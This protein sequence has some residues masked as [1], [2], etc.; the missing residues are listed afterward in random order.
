MANPEEGLPNT[1]WGRDGNGEDKTEEEDVVNEKMGLEEGPDDEL[2]TRGAALVEAEDDA[3]KE[4]PV[5]GDG[6]VGMEPKIEDLGLCQLE[7]KTLEGALFEL[8]KLIAEEEEAEGFPPELNMPEVPLLKVLVAEAEAE[9]LPPKPN[10]AGVAPV[11][12]PTALVEEEEGL[13]PKLNMPGVA[14][15]LELTALPSATAEALT[16]K[17]TALDVGP[18]LGTTAPVSDEEAEKLKPD[19][20]FELKT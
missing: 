12:D 15:L 11:V 2:K 16:P 4:N 17:T 5:D 1:G 10:I 3:P 18:L 19:V 6:G 14:V 13:R 7:P 8:T 9:D 20:V